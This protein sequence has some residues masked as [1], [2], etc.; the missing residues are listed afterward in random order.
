MSDPS[1]RVCSGEPALS[2][3]C[4]VIDSSTV[5]I[6]E[7]AS[8]RFQTKIKIKKS[9]RDF[10]SKYKGYIAL[11]HCWGNPT[12]EVK[13]RH[14]TTPENYKGRL[15]AI[16]L[17]ELPKTFQHAIEVVR[18]I[19]LSFLW[20]DAICIIQGSGGDWQNESRKMEDVFSAAYCTIAADSAKSWTDGFLERRRPPQYYETVKDG[21]RIYACDTKHDF[22]SHVMNGELNKRAW[23]L[24]ERVLSPRIL[25]FAEDHTYF[26]C[27]ENVC[28][29]NFTKLKR[30][31]KKSVYKI[32]LL[33]IL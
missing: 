24:Q 11:S 10:S 7:T 32:P 29:E 14:C 25:H 18:S 28:C 12:P 6:V 31:D 1:G 2:V 13:E 19:G 4:G 20:I 17:N 8:T 30:Y 3:S 9:F 15:K 23:V 22:E 5:K 21:R 27:G 33:L 16:D 26:A